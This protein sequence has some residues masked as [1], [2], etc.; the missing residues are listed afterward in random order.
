MAHAFDEIFDNVSLL[1]GFLEFHSE[2]RGD[3]VATIYE[4][5][6]T[7]YGELEARANQQANKLLE[8]GIKKGDRIAVLAK[9]VD[10]F[11]ELNFAA[12]KVGAVLVPVNFRLAPPEVA[13]VVNDAR[14]LLLFVGEDFTA[15]SSRSKPS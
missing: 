14:A 9:N 3:K 8:A 5:R 1:H 13:F 6:V 15:W 7:T 12:M 11:F 2:R 4:D 10:R